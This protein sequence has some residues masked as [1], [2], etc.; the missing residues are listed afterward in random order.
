MAENLYNISSLYEDS[1]RK[2]GQTEVLK[3][4][5]LNVWK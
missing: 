4:A 3:Q 2:D 1:S 5:R